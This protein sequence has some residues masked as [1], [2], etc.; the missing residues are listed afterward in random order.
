VIVLTGQA[1]VRESHPSLHANSV[2]HVVAVVACDDV[3]KAHS[4][5]MSE[6]EGAGFS[7][8]VGTKAAE[9]PSTVLGRT[10]EQESM[11]REAAERGICI[12]IFA[13]DEQPS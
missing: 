3:E 11:F 1:T 12:T 2:H 5:L 8:F 7:D 10:A 9:V 6:L 4:L 13:N